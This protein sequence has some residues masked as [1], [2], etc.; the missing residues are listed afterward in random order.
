MS[1]QPD[2]SG[3]GS[4]RLRFGAGLLVGT[5]LVA[6]VGHRLLTTS[7]GETARFGEDRRAVVSLRALTDV[8][9]RAG[10]GEAVRTVVAEFAKGQPRGRCDARRPLRRDLPRGLDRPRRHRRERAPRGA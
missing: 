4:H 9:A 7:L 3:K 10:S 8:V 6:A 1:D 5:I 2:E